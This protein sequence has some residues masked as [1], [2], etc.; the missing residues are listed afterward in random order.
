MM[1]TLG[2]RVCVY[3]AWQLPLDKQ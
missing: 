3:N 1:L 2:T